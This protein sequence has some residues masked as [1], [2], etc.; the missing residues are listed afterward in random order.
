MPPFSDP[1][2]FPIPI[3]FPKALPPRGPEAPA[4]ERQ[5]QRLWTLTTLS[6]AIALDLLGFGLVLLL[7]TL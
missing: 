4:E 5:G 6:Q 2:P 3:L 7:F 1:I